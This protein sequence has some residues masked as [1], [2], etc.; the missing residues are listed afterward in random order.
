MSKRRGSW[1]RESTRWAIYLRDDLR[2]VYCGVSALELAFLDWG[3]L[4][5]DHVVRDGSNSPKN[6]VT[7]CYDCNNDKGRKSTRAWCGQRGWNYSTIFS[8][9]S[10]VRRRDYRLFVAAA[11]VLLGRV[12][13]VPQADLVRLMK[14]RARARWAS[15]YEQEDWSRLDLAPCKA[16]G[17]VSDVDLA[18][19]LLNAELRPRL[20]VVPF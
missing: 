7:A 19:D 20:A 3:F 1:I 17:R 5:L 16:C 18:A 2:C 9:T 6:L 11:R 4:T 13:G 15:P 12:D 8:R 14:W 10:R